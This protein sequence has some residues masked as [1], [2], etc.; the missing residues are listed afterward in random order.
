MTPRFLDT[1]ISLTTRIDVV[2]L[3]GFSSLA[4]DFFYRFL[5]V[6][7]HDARKMEV[8][9]WNLGIKLMSA[10]LAFCTVVLFIRYASLGGLV[11]VSG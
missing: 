11:N 9:A 4:V 10:T 1:S 3:I 2:V 8:L 5:T 6:G 7:R